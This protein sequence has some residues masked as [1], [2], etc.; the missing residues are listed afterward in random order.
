L[1]KWYN[2]NRLAVEKEFVRLIDSARSNITIEKLFG[3]TSLEGYSQKEL[4]SIKK[5]EESK[6]N[7][8]QVIKEGSSILSVFVTKHLPVVKMEYDSILS[9]ASNHHAEYL[10][11][12]NQSDVSHEETVKIDG[13]ENITTP[14]ERCLRFSTGRVYVSECL[15]VS[16]YNTNLENSLLFDNLRSVDAVG[17]AY[18]LFE[19]FEKSKNHWALLTS[20]D[21][22]D[23]M[24]A[25][26]MMDFENNRISFVTVLGKD[27]SKIKYGLYAN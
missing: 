5:E 27:K 19:R 10:I 21:D 15:T 6:G 7:H 18:L 12:I 13:F 14:K 9:L 26:F 20:T 16:S 17:F 11:K 4:K 25:S 1:E 23:L 8:V 24:G 2:E 3:Y 22:I